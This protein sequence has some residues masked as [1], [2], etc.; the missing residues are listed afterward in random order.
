MKHL[1]IS[2]LALSTAVATLFTASAAAADYP[3]KPINVIVPWGRAATR[4]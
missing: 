2:I 4:I 1:R 3:V